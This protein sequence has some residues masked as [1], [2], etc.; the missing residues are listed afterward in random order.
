M[1]GGPIG[2][3]IGAPVSLAAR[4]DV[5]RKFR[6]QSL[7]QVVSGVD[8]ALIERLQ[9]CP[10]DLRL[11]DRRKFEEVVAEIFSGFGYEVELTQQTRD[12]GKDIVAI[13]RCEV[14]LR[15]LVEC[16]RPAPGNPVSVSAVRELLG[17][18][19]DDGA[20]KAI[21]ATT[22]YF[23]PDAKMFF[24]RHLWELEPRD[25]EGLNDWIAMYL[26]GT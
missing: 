8:R 22:T 23:T 14:N 10:D 24:E 5:E 21:L 7:I 15:F 17:V 12:G 11:I 25:F 19:S 20:S 2:S 26:K 18:K 16:R 4:F 1:I 9:Q 13:K 6:G 3:A